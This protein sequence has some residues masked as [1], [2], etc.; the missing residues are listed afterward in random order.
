MRKQFPVYTI[1]DLALIARERLKIKNDYFIAFVGAPG[2][3]KSAGAYKFCH[4]IGAFDVVENG[5]TIHAGDYKPERD[6]VYL[7]EDMHNL[8]KDRKLGIIHADELIRSAYNRDFASKE[9]KELVKMWNMYRSN[10]NVLAGCIPFF[11]DL[12]PDLRNLVDMRIDM[13]R[14]GVGIV[15][16][17]SNNFFSNDV[18]DTAYNK[19]IEESW[20]SKGKTKPNYWKLT[21][22]RGIVYFGPLHPAEEIKYERIRD[23]KKKIAEQKDGPAAGKDKPDFIANLISL[24]KMGRLSRQDI[25]TM[26]P[27]NGYKYSQLLRYVNER[28]K[29][30]GEDVT[31]SKL[32]QDIDKIRNKPKV[33][34]RKFQHNIPLPELSG[35]LTNKVPDILGSIQSAEDIST[36]KRLSI[37]SAEDISTT[38]RLSI[39]SAEDISTTKRL[40]K[41]TVVENSSTNKNNAS[42][43]SKSFEDSIFLNLPVEKKKNISLPKLST[44]PY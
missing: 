25:E 42:E 11:Y 4:K 22:F 35:T 7:R 18:W 30:M 5:E 19:K 21:T 23:E 36:T 12:D 44:N 37:Q 3:S 13:V 16:M 26:A 29:D 41:Q 10:R 34:E 1:A 2:S 14:R 43:K 15:H 24:G 6:M 39:Q 9:Q 8:M 17:R 31:F 32:F 33:E 40:S 28:L 27:Q 38:K 20:K